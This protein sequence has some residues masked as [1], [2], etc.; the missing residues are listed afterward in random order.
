MY[1]PRSTRLISFTFENVD[2]KSSDS[3]ITFL[4]VSLLLK[5]FN[6]YCNENCGRKFC[7]IIVVKLFTRNF[8]S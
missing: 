7:G 8:S 2:M 1:I 5:S 6:P 3:P 4:L